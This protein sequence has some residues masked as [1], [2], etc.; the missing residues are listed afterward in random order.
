M[1]ILRGKQSWLTEGDV[2]I[3]AS[4][5]LSEGRVTRKLLE[6]SPLGYDLLGDISSDIFYGGRNRRIYVENDT[7]GIPFMGS[8][9]MLKPDFNSLKF[10]SKKLTKN[11]D[12]YL[13]KEGW[14]LISRS[15][16]VGNTA[17]VNKDIENKAASEHIIR[18]V[19]KGHYKS[20][21]LYSFLSSKFGY[22]LMT[23]GMFGAV[24]QHIEP[25]YLASLP[26]PVMSKSLQ[27]K[28]H[29]LILEASELR[30]TANKLLNEADQLFHSLNEIEYSNY[31]ISSHEN[32]KYLSFIWNSKSNP[33]ISIKAKNHS[34]RIQ[35]IQEQWKSKKGIILKDYVVKPY[36]I[37]IRGAFKRI[38][39][40][41]I[42]SEMISQTD[43]HRTNPKNFKRVIVSRKSSQDLANDYQVLFPAVGN[44]SS[45]GEILFRP[46]LAYKSF[47][48]RLLS[49]DIGRFECASLKQAAYLLIALKSK[50]GFRMMR[51]YYYGTQLRRPLW[52]LLKHINIPIKDEAC[53]NLVS[54]KVIE[55]YELRFEADNKENQAICLI[56]KEIESWQK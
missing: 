9:D 10:I 16:T 47:S 56:E 3:D 49:G 17:Y 40:D 45:E 42:G 53:L 30:V 12:S 51:A 18:V 39:S 2:R 37:G 24:I 1:K 36:R 11:L 38:D 19:A 32:D 14:I 55:A 43:L 21:Y 46:T 31:H 20:G 22:S 27:L 34:K 48:N 23:Q 4:F 13:L 15:G 7:V 25:D 29:N 26:V 52:E 50:G 54:E 44:G 28:A 35:E 8:S 41:T 33:H 5:H 6:N